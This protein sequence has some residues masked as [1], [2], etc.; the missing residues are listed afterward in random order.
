MSSNANLKWAFN[1]AT[2]MHCPWEEEL[3]LWQKFGWN[4]AEIWYS[5]LEPQLA[6]GVSF[7]QL[8]RQMRDA[9]VKPIGMCATF[10]CTP[11]SEKDDP[12]GLELIEINQYLD[13]AAAMNA[14]SL[15]VITDGLIG[16]SLAAEYKRLVPKLRKVAD[17]AAER[18]VR[19][20]LEFLGQSKVNGTMGTCIELVNA[21]AHPNLGMLLDFCHYYVSASHIEELSLLASEKLFMVHVNDVRRYP[22]EIVQNEERCFPGEGRMDVAG[23][24]DHLHTVAGY[25]GYYSVELFDREIWKLQPRDTMQKLATSLNLVEEKLERRQELSLAIAC[26]NQ[27]SNSIW[28]MGRVK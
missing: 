14:E 22:M 21:T 5:K 6:K 10:V 8:S 18:G 16:E 23:M 12:E 11:S 9:G 27:E 7:A 15:T 13:A 28:D 1:S 4:A 2:I 24:I 25:E 3:S 26:S 19:L 17:M 20:N